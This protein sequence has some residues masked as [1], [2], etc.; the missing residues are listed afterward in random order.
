MASGVPAAGVS[1]PSAIEQWQSTPLFG[2]NVTSLAQA[3]SAPNVFYAGTDVAGV[4]RSDDGGETWSA[5][6]Q[7]LT[8]DALE[9]GGVDV[10]ERAAW[11]WLPAIPIS[12]MRECKRFAAQP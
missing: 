1:G 11:W 3:P 7:S 5:R 4:F 12:S 2:G 8:G 6:N 9:I 10:L